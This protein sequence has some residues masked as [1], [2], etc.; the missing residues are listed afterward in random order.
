MQCLLNLKTDHDQRLHLDKAYPQK[1]SVTQRETDIKE[2]MGKNV[3]KKLSH[4]KY[5][6]CICQNR[7]NT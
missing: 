1:N 3:K 4:F 2:D 5:M 7:I 6:G